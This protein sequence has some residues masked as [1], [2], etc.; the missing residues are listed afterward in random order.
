M[1]YRTP[2]LLRVG[3]ATHFVLGTLRHNHPESLPPQGG[4]TSTM[5]DLW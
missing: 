1:P 4:A 5:V 3:S 2:E